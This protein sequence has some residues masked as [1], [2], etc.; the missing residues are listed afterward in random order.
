LKSRF[1]YPD[2]QR[3]LTIRELSS[4]EGLGSVLYDD[5]KANIEPLNVDHLAQLA[6]V[7][8]ELQ[9]QFTRTALSSNT[10]AFRFADF[11]NDAVLKNGL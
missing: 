8:A 6:R 4:F 9:H 10:G 7:P 11:G 1:H 3:D 2:G 5:P